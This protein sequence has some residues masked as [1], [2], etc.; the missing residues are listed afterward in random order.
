MQTT[1]NPEPAELITWAQETRQPPM[2]QKSQRMDTSLE[3]REESP[4]QNTCF[5]KTQSKGASAT[6]AT[7]KLGA[8]YF[9]AGGYKIP[10]QLCQLSLP[11]IKS[12]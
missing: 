9:P 5:L 3:G 4:K 6:N 8:I 1:V 7:E 12:T 10:F 11:R 2:S